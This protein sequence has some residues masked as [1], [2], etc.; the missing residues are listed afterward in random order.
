M[1]K[2]ML[3]TLRPRE[4][5]SA[6]AAGSMLPPTNYGRES[7]GWKRPAVIPDYPF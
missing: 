3:G 1:R 2:W 5:Q 7:Y 4:L 6:I